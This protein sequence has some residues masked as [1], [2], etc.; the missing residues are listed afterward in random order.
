M[1]GVSVFYSK[2][3]WK[4]FG[5]LKQRCN[6]TSD[7]FYKGHSGSWIEYDCSGQKQKQG[8]ILEGSSKLDKVLNRITEYLVCARHCSECEQYNSKQNRGNSLYS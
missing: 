7:I 3:I 1:A 6:K 5:E 4:H 2:H 8:E